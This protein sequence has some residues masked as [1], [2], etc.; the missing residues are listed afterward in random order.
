MRRPA[1]L[2][3]G[4][5]A[6]ASLLAPGK[7]RAADECPRVV[8]YAAGD[9]V[10]VAARLAARVPS[11][12]Q[13]YVSIPPLT[14]KTRPRPDQAR[15]IRALGP[16][17]HALAEINVNGWTGWVR[18]NGVSWF[19]AGV[20]ARRRMGAAGYDLSLGDT[21]A[22]NEL[23]SAVRIGANGS[24]TNMR[25]FVRGL[26][27][28]DGTGVKGVVF[29]VGIGQATTELSVYQARLQD[30]FE[31]VGFWADMAAYVSD[32]SQEVYGD[33]RNYAA[34]GS[35]QAARR[36]RLVEYLHHQLLLARAAPA[37]A[38]A[39]RAFLTAASTPVAN[40]AWAWERDFGWTNVG[41]DA[42]GDY[43]AAQVDA[44]RSVGPRVGFAWAPRNTTGLAPGEF[45]A[46]TDAIL[47]RLA[48]ALADPAGGCSA[49][50]CSAQLEGAAA[51]PPWSTFA[52]WRPSQ[53]AIV[54]APETL[55]PGVPTPPIS[56]QLRTATGLP[57]TAGGPVPVTLTTASPTGAFATA[58]EGPWSPTLTVP[59]PSG[60]ASVAFHYLDSAP[61]RVTATAAGKI[62]ATAT[63]GTIQPPDT[64]PPDTTV[65]SAPEVLV[66]STRAV[67]AFVSEPGATFQCSLDGAPFAACAARIRYARLAQGR[68]VV[69]VRAVDAAGN[70]DRSPARVR[71][72][73]DTVPPVTRIVPRPKLRVWFAAAGE[74]GATYRCSLDGRRFSSCRSPYRLRNLAPGR[75]TF[76]VRATDAAG[77]VEKRTKKLVWRVG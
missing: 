48:A 6:A 34:P 26:Y 33:A 52:R 18:A 8:V 9:W 37:S 32:W 55:Q 30:W 20:E 16:N 1:L 10:R 67:L 51:T 71:W 45:R 72:T 41:F 25:D 24:R 29:T 53:L 39:A 42:M 50:G 75:H 36:A 59:I 22:V 19:D 23:T 54:G 56:V 11:C 4:L 44:L 73:V 66:R 28:G 21:W 31:D 58:P 7:A 46:Q 63:V 61:A 3:L 43:V 60:A 13:V 5:A 65:E 57:Y 14:D 76:L 47:D 35:D 74:R 68:H 62:A 40:A 70:V 69:A 17:F 12:S 2:A 64:A 49:T 38:D 77:N 15:R 27:T